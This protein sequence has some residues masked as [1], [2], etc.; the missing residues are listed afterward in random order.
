MKG[1]NTLRI[2]FAAAFLALPAV[3]FAHPV[4]ASHPHTI[5]VHD[6]TPQPHDRSITVHQGH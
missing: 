4:T 2:L 3:A 1:Q 6:R 5:T